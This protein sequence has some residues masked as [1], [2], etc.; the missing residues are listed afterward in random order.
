MPKWMW[1]LITGVAGA[2]GL[3][4]VQMQVQQVTLE[5]LNSSMLRLE[6]KADF[7]IST[8][9]DAKVIRAEDAVRIAQLIHEIERHDARLKA[10][11]DTRW[12]RP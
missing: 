4:T 8:L 10:L 2:L 3:H 1:V 11:E 9:G 7:A 6:Q 5:S 12:R